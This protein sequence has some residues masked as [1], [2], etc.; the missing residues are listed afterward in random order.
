MHVLTII[1]TN[2]DCDS[3]WFNTTDSIQSTSL[4]STDEGLTRFSNVI[5]PYWYHKFFKWKASKSLNIC[6]VNPGSRCEDEVPAKGGC[7]QQFIMFQLAF[8]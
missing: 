8:N 2:L 3:I 1:I 5:I 4:K 6:E 7:K